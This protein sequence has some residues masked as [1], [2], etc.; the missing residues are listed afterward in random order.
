MPLVFQSYY[1]LSNNSYFDGKKSIN[2]YFTD[3]SECRRLVR[4]IE[5]DITNIED[6]RRINDYIMTD[7]GQIYLYNI[8][9]YS[10]LNSNEVLKRIFK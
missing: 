3:Y 4:R 1:Y 6:E 10:S 5:F 9:T 8:A 7:L 2:E